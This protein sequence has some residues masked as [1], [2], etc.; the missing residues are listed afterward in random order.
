MSEPAA[1]IG[2]LPGLEAA[3]TESAVSDGLAVGISVKVNGTVTQAKLTKWIG[4]KGTITQRLGNQVWD[5]TFKGRN[6]GLAS[7]LGSELQAVQA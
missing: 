3:A 5:V 2:D 7:F 1:A 4:K 6:G